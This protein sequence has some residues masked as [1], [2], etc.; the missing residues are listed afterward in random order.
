MKTLKEYPWKEF[1]LKNLEAVHITVP[2]EIQEKTIPHI[3]RGRDVIG[4][5]KTGT[6]KTLAYLLPMIQK[7]EPEKRELQMLVLAPSRELSLQI[8]READKAVKNT[9]I[10]VQTIVEGIDLNRQLEKL[11]EKPHMV[12][13]TPGRL[14]HIIGLKKIKM[15]G[16]KIIALDE[17]DQILV[18]GLGE[19]VQAIIKSTLKERQLLSFSATISEEAKETLYRLM[20]EPL[21]INLD[22]AQPVP[23]KI[24]HQYIVSN[25]PK[26]TETL[27]E[28]L[29]IIKPS[30]ALIFI[31][32]NENVDR[33]VKTLQSKGYSVGGI[34]T[35]TNNQDRQHLLASFQK[36]QRKLLVTTD[37][38]TRGMDF[39]NVTHIFNMDLPLNKIDYLHRAGR[40]GRMYR[41]GTVINIIRDQEKF[42]M[43]KMMKELNI[44]VKAI[45]IIHEKIV[46]V[47]KI[48]QKKRKHR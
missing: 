7:I 46:P 26:K 8:Q 3:L 24:E 27:E 4:K 15:H 9:E 32:R 6:G 42:I 10:R 29:Q 5:A 23:E 36:G 2:T 33:F 11:K 47:E 13:A 14:M 45:T 43:Y 20:K 17:V 18:Q 22:E 35:R 21:F 30:K 25:A 48:I 41:E 28:L 1:I 34:Q 38:F 16:V 39:Q 19:K 12:I 44:Q 37:L 31:N 40:T